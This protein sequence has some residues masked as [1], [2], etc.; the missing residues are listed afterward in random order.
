L[1]IGSV[2]GRFEGVVVVRACGGVL[3]DSRAF[4]ER[5]GGDRAQSMAAGGEPLGV[6]VW[7]VWRERKSDDAWAADF[8]R[9]LSGK[10]DADKR[11][12]LRMTVRVW[13]EGG[14]CC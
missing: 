9:V 6:Q 11:E 7:K 1:G 8:D 3:A 13:K 12:A 5:A 4:S 10:T 14:G 2:R